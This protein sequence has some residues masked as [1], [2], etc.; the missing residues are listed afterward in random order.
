MFVSRDGNGARKILRVYRSTVR[1]EDRPHVRSV[2]KIV[3]MLF[4]L[5][6]RGRICGQ[7]ICCLPA[8]L[9]FCSPPPLL[10]LALCG[11]SGDFA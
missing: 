10:L 1:E 7:S 3:P 2:K 8:D 4:G 6:N 11:P 9:L 5:V